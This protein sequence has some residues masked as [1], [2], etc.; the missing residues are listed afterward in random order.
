[1]SQEITNLNENETT[2]QLMDELVTD[3]VLQKDPSLTNTSLYAELGTGMKSPRRL[4]LSTIRD[5][6]ALVFKQIKILSQ[7]GYSLLTGGSISFNS[8]SKSKEFSYLKTLL[9]TDSEGKE[10]LSLNEETGLV[11]EN[12]RYYLKSGSVSAAPLR[13]SSAPIFYR[14]E[15]VPGGLRISSTNASG[16]DPKVL[17]EFNKDGISFGNTKI[18]DTSISIDGE[19]IEKKSKNNLTF[20]SNIVVNG[21]RAESYAAFDSDV[22]FKGRTLLKNNINIDVPAGGANGHKKIFHSFQGNDG[23]I[24]PISSDSTSSGYPLNR[25]IYNEGD[26]VFIENTSASGAMQV[27]YTGANNQDYKVKCNAG[28][29]LMFVC[30]GRTGNKHKFTLVSGTCEN[31]A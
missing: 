29:A 13:P 8:D 20:Y 28:Q 7:G 12:G 4:S 3:E 18:T 15:L 14:G 6:L 5:V 10:L 31:V 9:V 25:E 24:L 17:G 19:L 22:D 30:R 21:F 27:S 1:M 16:A 23:N 26:V 2:L 11:F